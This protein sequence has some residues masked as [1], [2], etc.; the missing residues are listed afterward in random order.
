MKPINYNVLADRPRVRKATMDGLQTYD[1]ATIDSS[2]AFLNGEL[3]KLDQTLHMPLVMY[4]WMRDIDLREDVTAADEVSSF[5]NSTFAVAAGIN[6]GGSARGGKSWAGKNTTAITGIA[7]DIGKTANPLTIWAEQ[8]QWSLPELVSAQAL[9]R[10]VDSQKYEGMKLKWNMDADAQVYL[11]DST[12]NFTGLFNN[13]SVTATSVAVGASGSRLWSRKTPSEILADVNSLL[14]ATWAA[15]GWAVM[16]DQLRLPPDQYSYIISQLVS[17]AGNT[18]ILKFLQDNNLVKTSTGRDLNI[19]PVK[20]LIGA[21]TGGTVGVADGHNRMV[22]YTK[23]INYVRF[24]MTLLNRTPI[25]NQGLY[26]I[27]TYWNRFGVVEFVYPST[28]QYADGIG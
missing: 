15:A 9:G 5:T 17:S 10:P 16:P 23:N 24:P 13:A 18:S 20:W 25:Q 3:E 22:A 8:V 14:N 21:A 1:R 2:G 4:S 26:Q 7:L 6:G 28:V 19:Q 27:T 12:L 11:G